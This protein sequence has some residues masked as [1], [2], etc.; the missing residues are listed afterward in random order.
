MQ[1]LGSAD[2]ARQRRPGP[3]KHQEKADD[4]VVPDEGLYIAK[5]N[6]KGQNDIPKTPKV[7]IA[8]SSSLKLSS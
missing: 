1:C 6:N 2:L 3:G 4:D 7:R 5:A 8:R